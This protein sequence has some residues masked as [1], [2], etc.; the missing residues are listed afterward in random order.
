MI[1]TDF[2]YTVEEI[3]NVWVTL[4]DGTRLA[5][6]L[7]LPQGCLSEPAPAVLEYLPYRKDDGTAWQD[8]TRHPYFAGFG[9]AAVRVDIRGSGDSDGILYDEYLAQEQDDA[10]EVIAW[11]AE[12]PWCSGSVGMIGYSWGGFNGLQIAARRPPALGAIVTAY[13]TDDRYLDDCHHMG[14]CV[15]GSDLLKWASSMRTINSLPP[16]PRFRDDWRELWLDRL[17]RTPAYIEAWLTN[18]RYNDYWKH[19]SVA[20][21]YSAIQAAVYAVGG[22][23]DPYTNAVPRLMEHLSCPR[24]G[25]IGPWKHVL[26]YRGTP[27]P[28]IGF[29]Q[30]CIRWFDHHLKGVDNGIDAEPMMT[31]WMQEPVPPARDYESRPGRWVT[32]DSWPFE[33]VRR[34]EWALTHDRRLQPAESGAVTVLPRAV[35]D[36]SADPLV[37]IGDQLNGVTQGV[38][39]P[40]GMKAELSGDQQPDDATALT[41]DSEPLGA[42]MELLG[43]VEV[44]L[45]VT[46][47]QPDALVAARLCDVAPDGSSTLITWGLLNLT[48]RD[49]HEEPEPLVPDQRYSVRF[50]LNVIAQAVPA[51]HRVRLALSPTYWPSAWP[52]PVP[53]ALSTHVDGSSAVSLPVCDPAVDLESFEPRFPPAEM[54]PPLALA[55][56]RAERK[57]TIEHDE[58]IGELLMVDVELREQMLETTGTRDTEIQIDTWSIHS[59]RPLSASVHCERQFELEREGWSIRIRTVDEMCSDATEFIVRDTL[60]AWENGESVFRRESEKRI[61]RDLV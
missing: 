3:E 9:Y 21:D 32:S 22:W 48:H 23:A 11:I 34:E 14:G 18:Q 49:S 12:Q 58:D 16:D 6:R 10:L 13:S 61:P 55:G 59:A 42:R 2:P 46:A 53:V 52:S 4:S 38:W 36:F 50:P 24:K 56:D 44:R 7:W 1:R 39:C 45:D 19:G 25:L 57:R 54:S 8:S 35:P 29:L 15:L 37:I 33:D 60:E 28:T 27:E 20:E 31:V 26:P 17:E 5:A 51:G 47:D 41:F 43:V 40:N 30:E